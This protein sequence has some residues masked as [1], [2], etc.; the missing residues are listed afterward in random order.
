MSDQHERL[1]QAEEFLNQ[2]YSELGKER[3]EL[4]VRL[5]QVKDDIQQ[6]GF[7]THTYEEL[8]HGARMAWR[9]SNRCI[10]RFFWE[11]L[12][13]VDARECSDEESMAIAIFDHIKKATNGGNIVPYLTAFHPAHERG[14]IR[15]WNHQLI[16]YAGYVTEDG[17]MIGDPA[18][19][20]FTKVCQELGWE[21]KGSSFDILP[22]VIQLGENPPA[23]FPIPEDL[24]LEVPLTHPT[25]PSFEALEL[26]WYAL[27]IISDMKLVIGGIEYTAAPF[28]GWY[29]GTEIGARNLADTDRYNMLPRVAEL[30]QLDTS[31]EYTLWRDEALIELNKAVLF[32]FKQAGV[33]IVDHHTAAK[34]FER[35]EKREQDAGRNVTGKWSWLIPPISPATTHIFRKGYKDDRVYPNYF[36]QP[37]PYK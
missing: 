28:N 20:D 31:R 30:F 2:C 21:G 27:P 14:N 34:Q 26:K 35:F 32:S 12:K 7:Y 33:S 15:I 10:G 19:V 25:N 6:S 17:T 3:E 23:L 9:N 29:M 16:R 18:S 11:T 5:N 22:L 37:A 1:E 8:V 4:L 24:I 36:Y 13:V